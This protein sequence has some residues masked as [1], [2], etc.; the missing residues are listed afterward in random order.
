MLQ[1]QEQRASRGCQSLDS[2]RFE[3]CRSHGQAEPHQAGCKSA[4]V[5]ASPDNQVARKLVNTRKTV[6][7]DLD[8]DYKTR[9]SEDAPPEET[10]EEKRAAKKRA[11][12]ANLSEKELKRLEELDKKREFRKMQKKQGGK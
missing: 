4:P 11:E 5:C 3:H 8:K 6:D 10:A 12:R 9:Q 1:T 2:G 7:L